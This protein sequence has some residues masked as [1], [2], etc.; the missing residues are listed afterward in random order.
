MLP[1]FP[2]IKQIGHRRV[3]EFIEQNIPQF[4]PILA[5]IRRFRQHEGARGHITRVDASEGPSTI[6][7]RV[8]TLCSP[9]MR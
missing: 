9:G 8:S 5:D 4:A 2:D 3:R 6:R 1:D 7:K